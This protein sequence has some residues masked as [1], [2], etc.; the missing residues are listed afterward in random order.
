MHSQNKAKEKEKL[1]ILLLLYCIFTDRYI[2]YLHVFIL[3]IYRSRQMKNM[4]MVS[5]SPEG[6]WYFVLCYLLVIGCVETNPGPRKGKKILSYKKKSQKNKQYMRDYRCRSVMEDDDH[7]TLVMNSNT[8]VSSHEVECPVPPAIQKSEKTNILSSTSRQPLQPL[9]AAERKARSRLKSEVKQREQLAD[10]ERKQVTRSCMEAK[11]KENQS[12]RIWKQMRRTQSKDF[13]NKENEKQRVTMRETRSHSTH[14]RETEKKKQ[15]VAKKE[16]RSQCAEYRD[17]EKKKQQVAKKKKRSESSE[18]R[19]S[20]RKKQQVAKKKKR[21]E[22]SE[23]RD[24]EKKKDQ[25]ARKKKR[26][27]SSEYRDSERKK[28]QVAKKKKRTESSEY[29]DSEKKKDQEARKKKRSES[30]EYRDSERKKQQVAKKKK[31]S[32]SSE[33]RD[34]EKKKDQEAK[35][36]KRSESSEYRDSEKKKDQEARKKKRSESL[37]Y[38]D[39]EKKKDQEARKKKRSESLEYRGR[40]K[41][42][43]QVAKREKRSQCVKYRDNEKKKDKIAKEKKRS[44]VTKKLH[45]DLINTQ[46]K[47]KQRKD[48][49]YKEIERVKKAESR[50]RKRTLAKQEYKPAKKV[51]NEIDSIAEKFRI[52]IQEGPVHVCSSCKRTLYKHSVKYVPK[53]RYKNTKKGSMEFILTGYVSFDGHEYICMTCHRALMCGKVPVQSEYNHLQLDAIPDQLSSLCQLEQRLIA[54]RLPFMQICN[55]PRGAQKGIHGPVVN[56][57]SNLDTLVTTLPRLPSDAGLVPVKLKRKLQYKGHSMYQC[58][59]PSNVHKGLQYLLDNNML[60]T[61]IR[62][63]ED[64]IKQCLQMDQDLSEQLF[65]PFNETEGYEQSLPMNED[66]DEKDMSHGE[67]HGSGG[68]QLD[69]YEDDQHSNST[70][71]SSTDDSDSDEDEDISKEKLK[72]LP[73]NSCLQPSDMVPRRDISTDDIVSLAPG[74]KQKP[75]SMLTDTFSEVLSFP[76]QFPTGRF[77]LTDPDRKQF[78]TP[79][80]YFNQRVLNT[81]PRFARNIDYLF[82]SQYFTEMKQ[83]VDSVNIAMRKGTQGSGG[84]LKA[85]MMTEGKISELLKQDDGYRFI[86]SIRGSYPYWERTLS[87]LNAMVRQLGIPT[88]FLTLTAADL[89]W[90]ETIQVIARQYGQELSEEHI[91]EMSWQDRCTWIRSNPVTCARH[92]EFKYQ[93]F[94]KDVIMSK[95]HPIGPVRDFF[96]RVE[97]QQ[98]GSPHIHALFWVDGAPKI[99]SSKE[100]DVCSFIDKFISAQLPSQDENLKELVLSVQTHSHS[101]TCRKTG[102]SCRFHFPRPPTN[103]TIISHPLTADD[104]APEFLKSAKEANADILKKMYDILEDNNQKSLK[105][106][107]ECA[108]LTEEAYMQA[109]D[110]SS[111]STSIILKRKPADTSVNNFNPTLLK[112]W[113][114]NMDIQYVTD[115]WACAMYILS[116]ISKGERQMGKLL[117]EAS[118]ECGTD[119]SIRQQM[120]KV[121]NVFLSHREVSAQEAVYRLLSIPLKKSSRQTVFVNTGMPETR[122]HILKPKRDLEDL[123]EESEDIFQP[124]ILDRYIARPKSMEGTCLADFATNYKMDYEKGLKEKSSDDLQEEPETSGKK[125]RLLNKLGSIKKRKVTVIIRTP[126]FSKIKAPEKFYHSALMLYLP[127]RNEQKDLLAGHDSYEHHFEDVRDTINHNIAAYEM[128]SDELDNALE[129]LNSHEYPESAWD[130]LASETQHQLHDDLLE[131]QQPSE[132]YSYLDPVELSSGR[133]LPELST[134][135]AGYTVE[136]QSNRLSNQEYYNL[137]RSLNRD[138][139]PLFH[140]I[141]N[142]CRQTVSS[143]SRPSEKPEAFNIFLTG[144]AGTGKSHLVKAV[145]S[146]MRRELQLLCEDP[147]AVTVLVTA[148]TGVAAAS[149]DGTTIHQALSITGRPSKKQAPKSSVSHDKLSTMRFLLQNLK[150]LVID[151]ISMVGLPMLEDI[152]ERLQLIMGTADTTLYGGVSVLAVGDFHQLPPVRKQPVYAFSKDSYK[153]LNPTHL[154]RDLFLLYELT[155]IMRQKNS[156]DFAQLLNRVRL[157]PAHCTES[158][159]QVL[160]S[161][162]TTSDCSDYPEDA[163]H[164]F[165]SN[166]DV[167]N[168]NINMLRK[169]TS[170]IREIKAKDTVKGIITDKEKLPISSK[171]SETGGLR[172]YISLAVGARVMLTKNIAVGD[173]L[174]NGVQGTVTGFIEAH[175]QQGSAPP[176]AVLIKFDNEKV[177]ARRKMKLKKSASDSVPIEIEEAR[178]TVGTYSAQEVI[179]KQFPLTLCYA[180]TIHKVQGLSLDKIVVTFD[181]YFQGGHTYVALSRSRSLEGLY[182]RNFNKQYIKVKKD[183]TAE[184]SRLKERQLQTD[185]VIHHQEDQHLTICQLNIQSLPAHFQDLKACKSLTDCDII[186]LAETWLHPGCQ[187]ENYSMDGFCLIR[188]DRQDVH[189]DCKQS[190]CGMCNNKGGVAMYVKSDLTFQRQKDMEPDN[191]E[192]IIL[193]VDVEGKL[194]SY[195]INLYRPPQMQLPILKA[196]LCQILSCIPAECRVILIGDFNVNPGSTDHMLHIMRPLEEFSLVQKVTAPTHRFGSVLDH[197]YVS[198][199][200]ST[201]STLVV[202]MYFTDHSAVVFTVPVSLNRCQMKISSAISMQNLSNGKIDK[203][204][205]KK[206]NSR[207][208]VSKKSRQANFSVEMDGEKKKAVT[209]ADVIYTGTDAPNL[210][211]QDII[212]PTQQDRMDIS[213]VLGLELSCDPANNPSTRD[214]NYRAFLRQHHSRSQIDVMGMD[215]NCFFRAISKET[216]GTEYHHSEIR[217]L[218]CNFMESHPLT[219]SSWFYGNDFIDHITTMRQDKVWAEEVELIATASYFNNPIWEFTNCYPVGGAWKWIKIE[220]VECHPDDP[221]FDGIPFHGCFYIHHTGGVHYDRI[222]PPPAI[223]M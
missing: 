191:F 21:S 126:R 92:F 147:E 207:I 135:T 16:K 100:E 63:R 167:D 198:S 57:P 180:S 217:H 137:V 64:W 148:P 93:K 68:K 124:N 106:L 88:W 117:K 58:I 73:F 39:S 34:S 200:F 204:K 6:W 133:G 62:Q 175:P 189:N 208:K 120:K 1:F 161:R 209:K 85:G 31:R 129:K 181:K 29:R 79:K 49:M 75:L 213:L 55:L 196:S 109:L 220:P 65:G 185:S 155:E 97:F 165:S 45:D 51:L 199:S 59:N 46:S 222:L 221:P 66:T 141:L 98:R 142:W 157:G 128:N 206:K 7:S 22:S 197:V 69:P 35:K 95:A 14:Y 214:H 27:E 103:K 104:I 3:Y 115:P 110:R 176:A 13:R 15:Q 82:Y 169:L 24:S 184:M 41:K 173:G 91:N 4:V 215:G 105:Q 136:G 154:W 170:P 10:L 78:I 12:E 158:D 162:E 205:R 132:E 177:G 194:P 118:K 190:E 19:D 40:E 172:E 70:E 37:K 90:P 5:A 9:S 86:Q 130:K 134:S 122:I 216:L 131:G 76:A 192:C 44:D 26:S 50:R 56:V 87:D 125:I 17:T 219:F 202:P 96:Y 30:S 149:I 23:Y 156:K 166:A 183:V 159:I 138:Q 151:E 53:H 83:V 140:Y 107:L 54:Q 171:S 164:V 143:K 60:Y 139:Q 28:Q 116:Y 74:E 33:Y 119:D 203:E 201:T 102:K 178:F 101:G 84:K 114:A 52:A 48:P 160:K 43:Q 99:G 163:L 211:V 38:R 111:G 11:E 174:V 36:K 47:Q 145:V 193:S 32:E 121:G 89:R 195:V 127:W 67:P 81:D 42:K 77:G 182:L 123:P 72:G 188:R 210:S 186:A 212:P 71:A 179:R 152:N 108:S 153:R 94:L 168:H 18:Y 2:V 218:I 61:D 113:R 187:S 150:V 25:E 144:G 112:I 8:T 146:M 20:E 223:T 80:K